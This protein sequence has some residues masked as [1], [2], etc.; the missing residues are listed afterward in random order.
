MKLLMMM[1]ALLGCNLLKA[2][3]TAEY[4]YQRSL[5]VPAKGYYEINIPPAL[6]GR[7][8]PAYSDL[9]LYHN[10]DSAKAPFLWHSPS[11]QRGAQPLQ[12]MN[13]G[14]RGDVFYY[15]VQLPAGARVSGLDLRFAPGNFQYRAG[16]EGSS[17]GG[18]TWM[19]LLQDEQLTG[20]DKPGAQFQYGRLA[21]GVVDF[22]LLRIGLISPIKPPLPFEVL[23]LI[24]QT[25]VMP[26]Q[27]PVTTGPDSLSTNKREQYFYGALTHVVPINEIRLQ[28]SNDGPYRRMAVLEIPTDTLV[29][30]GVSTLFWQSLAQTELSSAHPCVF[31][32]SEEKIKR[33]R[34]VVSQNDN[35][36]FATMRMEALGPDY[37][38]RA[39]FGKPG[40][41]NLAY[42]SS[43]AAPLRFD[44]SGLENGFP[45]SAQ[46]LEPGNEQLMGPGFMTHTSKGLPGWM[47]YALLGLV[48]VGLAVFGGK[49][50]RAS[51]ANT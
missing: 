18:R 51:N 28:V 30:N 34:I 39:Y 32:F 38:L 9:W 10:D 1:L 22:P 46:R 26:K 7:L 42:G 6:Y 12:T 47:L 25:P 24:P 20:V 44:L 36:P 33:F 49:L 40:L 43:T 41:W 23:A 29:R 50:L 16:V 5:N 11:P 19:V 45:D 31:R 3:K 17:D 37:R 35:A 13:T 8:G 21:T 4:K 15:T 2:Q 27:Y 48:V 14:R